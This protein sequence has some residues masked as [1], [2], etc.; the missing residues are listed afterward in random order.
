MQKPPHHEAIQALGLSRGTG[1]SPDRLL[2]WVGG[3]SLPLSPSSLLLLEVRRSH[4]AMVLASLGS[5]FSVLL[6][7]IVGYLGLTR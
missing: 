2:Q 5:F 4:V 3:R 1:A 7:G 6:L